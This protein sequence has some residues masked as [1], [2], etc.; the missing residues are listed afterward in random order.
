MNVL[1]TATSSVIAANNRFD[2]A[3]SQTVVDATQGK[4]ILSDL[5]DQMNARTAFSASISVVKTADAM[6]GQ[7]L[8]IRA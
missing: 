2:K 7:T 1:S 6:L 3:A 4:D 5:V 8:D